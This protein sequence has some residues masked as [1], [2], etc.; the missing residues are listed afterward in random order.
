MTIESN[1]RIT[2]FEW[3]LLSEPIHDDIA[4]HAP[5][6]RDNAY[7]CFW[8]A[9][10]DVF[11]ALHVST[12][13]NAEGRRSRLS[14]HCDDKYIEIVEPLDRG[15]FSSRSVTFDLGDR[16][17]IHSARVEGEL[18]WEPRFVMADYT[19]DNAPVAYGGFDGPPL[20]HF[21]RG[22]S[23]TGRLVVDGHEL[24]FSGYGARDRTW[25]FRDESAAIDELIGFMWMFP[26]HALTT[27]R[28]LSSDGTDLTLGYHLD[29]EISR[30]VEKFSVTRD[31]AGLFVAST[32]TLAGGDQIAVRADRRGA[33]WCPLGSEKTG[34]T[35]SAFDEFSALRN[36]RGENGFGMTTQGFVK[37]LY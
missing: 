3:G 25:G 28:L 7:L 23:V 24:P 14:L 26:T 20:Q 32:L 29:D 19:G 4:P 6:W 15:S 34:P 33:H 30:P 11:G 37:R 22:A 9:D 2:P 16:F 5:P 10:S 13:P 31:A 17:A 18:I 36:D 8:D 21:Q 35:H 1:G 27:I 12:S